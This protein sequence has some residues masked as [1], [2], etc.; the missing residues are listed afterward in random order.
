MKI[1]LFQICFLFLISLNSTA[2][3]AKTANLPDIDDLKAQYDKD[4]PGKGKFSK[5]WD[6]IN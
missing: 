5:H 2:V 6:P 4:H 1:R 3:Y